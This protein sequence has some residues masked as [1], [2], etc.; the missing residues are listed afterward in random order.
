ML[1]SLIKT[2]GRIMSNLCWRA[3]RGPFNLTL[4]PDFG[5][6]YAAWIGRFF[7]QWSENV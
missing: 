5:L 7:Y 4:L 1:S 3:S 2:Q 6:L